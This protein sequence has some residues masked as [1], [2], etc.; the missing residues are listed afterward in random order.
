MDQAPKNVVNYEGPTLVRF[1]DAT[2]FLW[3]DDESQHVNDYI[4]GKNAR[5]GCV[6]F[7]LRPGK[8]FKISGAWKPFYNQHRFYYVVQG[9]LTIQDPETGDVVVAEAGEAVHWRGAK[10]HFGYNFSQQEVFVLDWYAPQERPQ[11]ITEIEYNKTKPGLGEIMSGRQDLLEHWPE[12]YANTRAAAFE[13]GSVVKLTA[14]DS[15]NFVQGEDNPILE[16]I[17]VSSEEL[18]GGTI[19]LLPSQRSDDRIHPGEKIIFALNGK[20]NVYLPQTYDWF[21]LFERDALYLP[22]GTVHQIWNY[23][24]EP[25]SLAF[26][27]VPAYA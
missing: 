16:R 7:T 24:D 21:E 18:T 10:W 11:N 14:D 8:F 6:V 3:G 26:K 23:S 22:A 5:I 15:I 4:Y 25:A 1:Q 13:N 9:Q 19:D 12:A 27:V 2:R 20:V 17:F